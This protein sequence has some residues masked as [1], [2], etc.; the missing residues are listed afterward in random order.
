M[1][2]RRLAHI[3]AFS[4]LLLVPAYGAFAQSAFND[5]GAELPQ[6]AS[7]ALVAVEPKVDA[8][9]IDPGTN[10]SLIV[11]FRNESATEIEFKDMK[12]FPSSNVTAQIT[13]DQCS[14]EPLQPSAQ[15]AVVMEVKGLQ[16]GAFR[17]EVLARH[18]GRSRLVTATVSGS[19][20]QTDEQTVKSS[21]IEITP[22]TVDFGK[23]EASRP[24][25]RSVTLR[26]ITSEKIDVND[27]F[28]DA[29][30]GSG[31]SLKTDCKALVAG[32]SCIASIVWSP[33]TKGPTSGALVVQHT[34]STGVATASITGEFSPTSTE[35]AKPFPEPVPGKGLL[36][37]SEEKVD[38]GDGIESQS[39]ITV[40]LVNI[41]DAALTLNDIELAG[42]EQGLKLDQN[43]CINNLTLEP[44]EA[45]PLTITW[46]P[47]K[48]G[49]V[50]DDVRI[51]HT[52][53]RGILVL[54][55]RGT[56]TATVNVD[57]KPI[58][59]VVQETV[60]DPSGMGSTPSDGAKQGSY[61]ASDFTEVNEDKGP[62]VLDGYSITSLARKNAIISGPGG[63]RMV[64]DGQ[65]L[66]LA[67][68]MWEVSITEEG[69]A[70]QSG[71]NRVLL[72]FDRSLAAPGTSTAAT[73]S[74]TPTTGTT[75]TA[76]TAT[77]A[78]TPAQ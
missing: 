39:S 43:G 3:A 52:G 42:S 70:M 56:S 2:L 1:T 45:C 51:S 58:V 12:L 38:F 18:T 37:A 11:Q 17:V 13:S 28:I 32:A 10:N 14:S 68:H 75:G 30:E 66:R 77:T 73:V 20:E 41:G 69:V 50:I 40:S 74:A 34:G 5:P 64:R 61:S 47:S 4:A 59:S 72:L 55:V 67:G 9:T 46:A 29:P 57:S 31:F 76:T 48:S 21:D 23:L 65:K 78:T 62:P 25:I 44:T 33:L 26:N 35:A 22:A 54:P 15:C 19:V 36:I 49:A 53:A 71:K 27:L 7:G 63:S 8:G 16:S 24:I 6:G 60:I